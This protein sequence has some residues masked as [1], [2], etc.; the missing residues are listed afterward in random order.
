MWYCGGS[1]F[2]LWGR[3][4]RGGGGGVI[5]AGFLL[6][7]LAVIDSLHLVTYVYSGTQFYGGTPAYYGQLC[8][9]PRKSPIWFSLTLP[10]LKRTLVNTDNGHFSAGVVNR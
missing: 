10:R 9:S 3:R 4:A 5:Q 1:S 8:L 2:A 7:L 6:C